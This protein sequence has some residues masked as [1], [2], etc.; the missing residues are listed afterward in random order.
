MASFFSRVKT[1]LPK[2]PGF[3]PKPAPP[4]P[5]A[6]PIPV[7]PPPPAG[8]IPAPPGRPAFG[9]LPKGLRSWLERFRIIKPIVP[10]PPPLP[11]P[12]PAEIAEATNTAAKKLGV[13]VTEEL[14]RLVQLKNILAKDYKKRL[15]ESGLKKAK[16]DA[17]KANWKAL[18][19]VLVKLGYRKPEYD[20]APGTS[21]S[22]TPVTQAIAA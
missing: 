16:F 6:G 9:R 21:P 17:D 5:H 11:P 10:P 8:P 14:I 19:E 2:I 4:P 13:P 20:G 12:T 15:R 7:P 3:P 18:A 1:L 22:L